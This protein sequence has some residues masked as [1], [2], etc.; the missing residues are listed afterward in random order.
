MID[1]SHPQGLRGTGLRYASPL[2]ERNRCTV[3]TI[4]EEP[5]SDDRSA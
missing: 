3:S 5:P 4:V 1:G 2:S